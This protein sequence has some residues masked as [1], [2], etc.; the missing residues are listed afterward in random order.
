MQNIETDY[1]LCSF[2]NDTSFKS[3]QNSSILTS[4]CLDTDSGHELHT[5]VIPEKTDTPGHPVPCDSG[6]MESEFFF[7]EVETTDTPVEFNFTKISE[8][9]KGTAE[10]V[11]GSDG[12]SFKNTSNQTLDELV[13]INEEERGG[14]NK[15]VISGN[16]GDVETVKNKLASLWNNVKYG[17]FLYI[18]LGLMICR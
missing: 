6:L 8:L 12:F 17:K 5:H 4:I 7:Q 16:G 15:E 18:F 11:D 2:M 10:Q 3:T 13:N 9:V 1:S 14:M